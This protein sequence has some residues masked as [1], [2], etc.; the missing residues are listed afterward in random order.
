MPLSA[1]HGFQ[2]TGGGSPPSVMLAGQGPKLI[3]LNR[4]G[5]IERFSS[6]AVIL[7]YCRRFA[8]SPL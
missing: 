8:A 7:N 1:N 3:L 5:A 2:F 6:P 4:Y